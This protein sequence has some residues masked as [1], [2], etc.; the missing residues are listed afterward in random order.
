MGAHETVQGQVPEQV[1]KIL[2]AQVR[3]YIYRILIAVVPLLVLAGVL[4]N[5]YGGLLLSL[6]GTVL[7]VGGNLLAAF[8]VRR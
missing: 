7:G 4:T 1:D 3:L 8:N 6:A 5:Q 2:P